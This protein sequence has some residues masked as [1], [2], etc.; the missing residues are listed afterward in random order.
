MVDLLT[1]KCSLFVDREVCKFALMKG[2]SENHENPTADCLAEL[3]VEAGAECRA[4]IGLA[5]A[6]S[7]S[8]TAD[9]PSSLTAKLKENNFVDHSN[10]A[11]VVLEAAAHKL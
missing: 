9:H 4:P 3:F 11:A 2:L 6:S 1:W 7:K 10:R 8:N 5:R